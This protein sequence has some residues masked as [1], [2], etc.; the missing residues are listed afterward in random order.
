MPALVIPAT[1]ELRAKKDESPEVLGQEE[2]DV[3]LED[4]DPRETQKRTST[5]NLL[6]VK[7]S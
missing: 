6:L 3:S 4:P 5:L 7:T 1:F 2:G